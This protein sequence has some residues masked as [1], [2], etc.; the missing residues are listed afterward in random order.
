[1]ILP[2]GV[3]GDKF[4]RKRLLLAALGVFGVGSVWRALASSAALLIAGRCVLGL[5]AA[6]MMP[7]SMAVLPEQVRRAGADSLTTALAA[8]GGDGALRQGGGCLHPWHGPVAL[9]SADL[10][11]VVCPAVPGHQ[12]APGDS[13]R[14]GEC[15]AMT[16]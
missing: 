11:V 3:L 12:A 4:G 16:R 8:T 5:G 10:S 15:V 6:F 9:V 7:L 13:D 1:M 2:A 14:R